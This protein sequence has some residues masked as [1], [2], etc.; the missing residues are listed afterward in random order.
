M[1]MSDRWEIDVPFIGNNVE[2]PLN[3]KFHTL[4][5]KQPE[6]GQEIHYFIS[7]R[8]YIEFF[9]T[10]V[11]I[12]W[13]EYDEDGFTGVYFEYNGEEYLDDKWEIVSGEWQKF[14]YKKS[15]LINDINYRPES[16]HAT[17]LYWI[18]TDAIRNQL[19]DE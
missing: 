15:Y 19:N 16:K 3:L 1:K 17:T 8:R 11:E 2:T 9:T 5:H 7:D 4:F 12:F 10:T 13:E 14:S 18:S 6:N